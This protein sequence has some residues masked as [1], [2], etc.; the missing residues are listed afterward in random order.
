MRYYHSTADNTSIAVP[1]G[2]KVRI[3]PA[4]REISEDEYYDING[5]ITVEAAVEA[6]L[7]EEE[8][9]EVIEEDYEDT[10]D[11][12]DDLLSSMIDSMDSD[13]EAVQVA[14]D[15]SFAPDEAIVANEE[16]LAS[17]SFESIR[18]LRDQADKSKEAR[19]TKGKAHGVYSFNAA[20]EA[21]VRTG[22]I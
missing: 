1:D 4:Y 21:W 18:T 14:E 16:K 6:K 15:D 2:A 9:E 12:D 5:R 7:E 11:E 3:L 10:A 22:D 20:D 17:N 8:L 13:D 19:V